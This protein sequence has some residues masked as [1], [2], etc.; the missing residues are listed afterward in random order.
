MRTML[1]HTTAPPQYSAEWRQKQLSNI[2]MDKAIV[3]GYN[4]GYPLLELRYCIYVI[5][6]RKIWTRS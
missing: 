5:E 6:G 1:S 4:V 3:I 2:I